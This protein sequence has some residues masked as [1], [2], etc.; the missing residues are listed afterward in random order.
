MIYRKVFKVNYYVDNMSLTL[1]G[2][3]ITVFFSNWMAKIVVYATELYLTSQGLSREFLSP[4]F[5][6]VTY[7]MEKED[8]KNYQ[9]LLFGFGTA[10]I[11]GFSI[12]LGGLILYP[13]FQRCT[14]DISIVM[15]NEKK[16]SF[17]TEM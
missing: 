14:A 5:L 1:I 9:W 15:L 12:P 13:V 2:L 8:K 17:E 7:K 3:A 16:L 11:V 10:M 6:R 4:Y